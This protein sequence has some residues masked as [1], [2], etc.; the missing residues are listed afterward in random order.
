VLNIS[1][2]RSN[3]YSNCNDAGQQVVTG[4]AIISDD[5]INISRA[6]LI[7]KSQEL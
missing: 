3:P 5:I 4:H 7:T 2:N 6:Q 1:D